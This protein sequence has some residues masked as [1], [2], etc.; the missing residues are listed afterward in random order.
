MRPLLPSLWR[1]KEHPYCH[2]ITAGTVLYY[3]NIW[4]VNEIVGAATAFEICGLHSLCNEMLN[5]HSVFTNKFMIVFQLSLWIPWILLIGVLEVCQPKAPG[6]GWR[7]NLLSYFWEWKGSQL[8]PRNSKCE[9]GWAWGKC[10]MSPLSSLP[11]SGI[12]LTRPVPTSPAQGIGSLCPVRTDDG[13]GFWLALEVEHSFSWKRVTCQDNSQAMGCLCKNWKMG[14][15]GATGSGCW[16]G[17]HWPVF[18]FPMALLA[19]CPV[20]LASFTY[21][22]VQL[23]DYIV[24]QPKV[25][26]FPLPSIFKAEGPRWLLK[27][28][29]LS[30]PTSSLSG[31]CLGTGR[32]ME[33]AKI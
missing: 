5:C 20:N 19:W 24:F 21:S 23:S 1:R 7:S 18:Q 30:R 22:E 33:K 29:F 4:F 17:E 12:F 2:E 3:E 13:C 28:C 15:I 31:T 10:D 8:L 11:L 27:V 32:L 14:F 6:L 25:V 16:P 9:L 26:T